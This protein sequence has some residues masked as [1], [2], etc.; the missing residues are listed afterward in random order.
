[1][2]LNSSSPVPNPIL[3]AVSV[4]GKCGACFQT[5]SNM[6]CEHRK[7]PTMLADHVEKN[8]LQGKLKYSL[9]VGASS[10]AETENRWAKLNMIDRR[11]PHQVGKEIAKGINNGNI[12]FFDKHLSMFPVDLVYGFYTKDKP[13]KKLDVVI[14]EATAIT[15]DGGIIPGASVGA[16]PELIQMADKVRRSS[17]LLGTRDADPSPRSLSKSTPPCHLLKASTIS[18]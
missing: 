12:N 2:R 8:S 14:V 9:F 11:S 16:S 13:N 4:T 6:N 17:F 18:Q 10:G 15:E 7:I 5:L 3:R 1:V